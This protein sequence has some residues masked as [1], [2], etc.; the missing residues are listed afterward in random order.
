M[1]K[2]FAIILS[3]AIVLSMTACGSNKAQQIEQPSVPVEEPE[4]KLSISDLDAMMEDCFGD[5]FIESKYEDGL[6]GV[7][8]TADGIGW[9]VGTSEF[10]DLCDAMSELSETIYSLFDID[11]FI[12]LVDDVDN[13]ILYFATYNGDDITDEL[14]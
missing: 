6:Y 9:A 7:A 10:Y 1:K 3:F 5:G 12:I 11:N 2:I 4:L 14:S 8:V 13:D